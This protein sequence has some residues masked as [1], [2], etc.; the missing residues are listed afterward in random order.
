MKSFWRSVV[1]KHV[2]GGEHDTKW[3]KLN[4]KV[5]ENNDPE[6]K[7]FRMRR[8]IFQKRQQMLRIKKPGRRSTCR[9]RSLVWKDY[10]MGVRKELKKD[11][12]ATGKD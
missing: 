3:R 4:W 7:K 11:R 8:K 1:S 5:V 2:L 10:P 9:F 12:R 6:R